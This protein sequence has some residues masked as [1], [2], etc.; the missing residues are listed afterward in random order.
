MPTLEYRGD[1]G[2]SVTLAS[3]RTASLTLNGSLPSGPILVSSAYARIYVS[4]TAKAYTF[5]YHIVTNSSYYGDKSY[6]F[7][8]NDD[9]QYIDVPITVTALDPSFPCKTINTITVSETGGHGGNTRIRGLV[10][11]FVDY[12]EVGAPTLPTNIRVNGET[13]IN[14]E[15]ETNA[16]LTWTAGALGA[17]DSALSYRVRRYNVAT[18][19]WDIIG[20]TSNTYMTITAPNTDSKSYYFYV[21]IL[22]LYYT[23]TST[24]YASIYTFIQLTVPTINGGGTNPVYNPRPMF[25]VTL[26]NG[27]SDGLLALVANGWTASRQGYPGDKIYLMRNS[28]Y[29]QATSDSVTMT[30][31]DQLMRSIDKTLAVNYAPLTYTNATVEAGTTIVKAADITEL[32][33]A[34]ANIRAAYGMSAYTFTA[35]VAGVT[36]LTLW[37]TH[38]AEIQACINEIKNYINAWDTVSTT[39]HVILPTMLT[40]PGPSADV[41]NQLRQIVTML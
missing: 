20:I 22:T 3:E 19:T 24:T 15:A 40:A 34:L 29:Q 23:R 37:A 32:Q 31:T 39:F 17:Y 16:T 18:S 30:E 21:D 5:Q 9:P 2:A 14:L 6:K 25:L 41:L 36:S 7:A 38:I 11:I 26:G 28:T 13:A 35:C 8:N 12:V 27:P 33:T 1:Y 10:R 4:T